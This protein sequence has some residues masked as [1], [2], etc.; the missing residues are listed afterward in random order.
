MANSHQNIHR[1]IEATNPS[2]G[3]IAMIFG[4]DEDSLQIL[5]EA[6]KRDLTCIYCSDR[7][8]LLQ[9]AQKTADQVVEY[10]EHVY[11]RLTEYAET[12]R[13]NIMIDLSGKPEFLTN[14]VKIISPAGR[15]V[16]AC[17]KCQRA[18]FQMRVVSHKELDIVGLPFTEDSIAE[19]N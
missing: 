2:Q 11:A 19:K 9:S 5:E 1:I 6:K 13:P 15:I 17:P 7:T 8:D 3:D 10:S 18:T 14:A 12:E 16:L 4:S